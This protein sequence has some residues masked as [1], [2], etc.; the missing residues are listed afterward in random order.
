VK[1]VLVLPA[2][3]THE[4]AV[5]CCRMLEQGI[6]TDPARRSWPMLRRCAASI[7]RRWRCCSIAGARRWPAGKSLLGQGLALRG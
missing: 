4:H 3:L 2:E 7:P 1:P 5:A 6:R